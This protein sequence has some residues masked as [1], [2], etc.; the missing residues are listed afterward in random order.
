MTKMKNIKESNP[1][2]E[3]TDGIKLVQLGTTDNYVFAFSKRALIDFRN[4]GVGAK[5]ILIGGKKVKL[6]MMNE[7]TFKKK[8]KQFTERIVKG[9]AKKST[10]GTNPGEVV[11]D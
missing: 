2:V 5:E 11:N 6:V 10:D 4:G 7:L 8:F 9:V 1:D 3:K